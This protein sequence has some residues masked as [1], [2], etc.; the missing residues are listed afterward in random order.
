MFKW[1]R[2]LKNRIN[3]KLIKKNKH[4]SVDNINNKSI[5]FDMINAEKVFLTKEKEEKFPHSVNSLTN[6]KEIRNKK[7]ILPKL[8]ENN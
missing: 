6:L 4:S 1:Y 5:H 8:Y 7:R 2:I 3:L